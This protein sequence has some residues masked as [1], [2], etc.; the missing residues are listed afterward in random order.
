MLQYLDEIEREREREGEREGE[1]ESEYIS[2][3][4]GFTMARVYK[5]YYRFYN[6]KDMRLLLQVY[7]GEDIAASIT[8]FTVVRDLAASI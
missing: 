4:T 1:R 6:G 7:G 5:F 3:I 8:G 2:S